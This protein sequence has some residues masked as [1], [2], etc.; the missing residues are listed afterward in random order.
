MRVIL[1]LSALSLVSCVRERPGTP[2]EHVLLVTVE[3]L[4]ADHTHIW[5]YPRHTT[6][7]E[8]PDDQSSLDLDLLMERGVLYHEAVSYTHLRAH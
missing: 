2:P 3:N 1:F 7:I 5:Q 8:R 4:R 6:F